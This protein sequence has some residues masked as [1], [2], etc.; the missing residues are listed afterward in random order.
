M[1]RKNRLFFKGGVYGLY[2]TRTSNPIDVNDIQPEDSEPDKKLA[3][4][5]KKGAVATEDEIK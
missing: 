3:H 5:G 2:W 1:G 4:K